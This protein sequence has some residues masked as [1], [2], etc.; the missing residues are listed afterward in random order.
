MKNSFYVLYTHLNQ[1]T[2]DVIYA[3]CSCKAIQR[4]CCKHEA[5]LLFT[6]LDFVN[7]GTKVI[8]N[9]L[10][11]TQVS[12][13]WHIP[14][15]ANM[16]L[17]K[18]VRFKDLEFEKAEVNKKRKRPIVSGV[19]ESFCATPLFAYTKEA[20]DLKRLVD[21]FSKAGRVTLFCDAIKSNNYEPCTSFQTSVSRQV[22][23]LN[24]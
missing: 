12:Q 5:A 7:L 20:D 9:D 15:S 11:C 8:S 10:T 24:K 3:K 14:T 17:A 13:K 18:A 19:R 2:G 16:T 6:L 1:T 21:N 4:C 23:N 22:L